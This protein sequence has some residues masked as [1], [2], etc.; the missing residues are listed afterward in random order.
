MIPRPLNDI[1]EADLI[2]LISNGVAE[3]R[4]IDYKRTLPGG[5]DADK[6]EFLADISSFAN[7]G[8]GDVV[9]GMDE[10]GG[11]PTQ[12]V[13]LQSGDPDAEIR[14]LDSIIG[15]GL[16]PRIRYHIRTVVTSSGPVV[17]IRVERSW[18]GPHRVIFGGHDKF[19]G[20]NSA[21]KY[22]LDV[23]EVRAAFTLSNT[24]TERIRSFRT[25]R[26][27]ALANNQ[28]PLPF[29]ES[30]KI[31]MHCIPLEAFA[32][33]PQLDLR[34]LYD[35]TPRWP[36]MGTTTFNR[37]L[38]LD[39]LLI[40][41]IHQPCFSYTQVYRTGVLEAVQGNL[42]A[43]EYEG[44][45]FIPS[46]AY[47]EY[48]LSYFRQALQLLQTIGCGAPLAV[49]LSL[50]GT[51]G[52]RMGVDRYDLM[53]GFTIAEDNIVL[54]ETVIEDFGTPAEK[55]LKPMFDLV[56]NACGHRESLNFDADGNWRPRR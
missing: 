38:N 24:A 45:V 49:A 30:P 2:A 34:P 16:S 41:G 35:Q 36:P 20:R 46:Q 37:R 1:A 8:G 18:N 26:L 21:G 39:G 23:N 9:Y 10:T 51:K 3:G 50:L 5:S 33:E 54:P 52:L 42:L 17:V 13:A 47:E 53:S 25:D 12:V 56:W 55:I 7:S 32:G 19:Y 27:I 31:V 40:Y 44:H 4:T 22:P 28:T 29:M 15:A 11:I 43:R 14:R 48:I 6:K